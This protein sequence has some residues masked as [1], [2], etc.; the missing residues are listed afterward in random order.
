MW[1]GL[2]PTPSPDPNVLSLVSLI[3]SDLRYFYLLVGK[4]LLQLYSY[5][6]HSYATKT[7]YH[8]YSNLTKIPIQMSIRDFS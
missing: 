3:I 6:S 1:S 8:V 2:T 7:H 4:S 5:R